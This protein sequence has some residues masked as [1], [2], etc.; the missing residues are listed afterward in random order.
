MAILHGP[1]RSFGIMATYCIHHGAM[2]PEIV[3]IADRTRL[4]L[5]LADQTSDKLFIGKLAVD[6]NMIHV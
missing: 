3:L 1:S 5:I 6:R 4:R 2:P